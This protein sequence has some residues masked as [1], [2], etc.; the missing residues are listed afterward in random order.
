MNFAA[1][2][3]PQYIDTPLAIEYGKALK[4]GIPTKGLDRFIVTE[5]VAINV[6]SHTEEL[7]NKLENNHFVILLNSPTVGSFAVVHFFDEALKHPMHNV[8]TLA[9]PGQIPNFSPIIMHNDFKKKKAYIEEDGFRIGIFARI[10]PR[11]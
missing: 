9:L 2:Q 8:I 7:A 4:T 6:I 11:L 1:E 5:S 3:I 10:S